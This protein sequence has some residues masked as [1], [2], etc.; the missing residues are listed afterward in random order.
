VD[1]AQAKVMMIM[2]LA[3]SF[4]F[5]WI[6]SGVTLY[7]LTGNV[8]GIGQQYFINHYWSADALAKARPRAKDAKD[9]PTK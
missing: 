7:W 8:V 5:L 6:Q 9:A 4:M 2:P 1:P 3:L